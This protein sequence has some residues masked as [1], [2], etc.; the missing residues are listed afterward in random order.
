[1]ANPNSGALTYN[2]SLLN[3]EYVYPD[4]VRSS[5]VYA[6]FLMNHMKGVSKY[7]SKMQWFQ[8]AISQ[9]TVTIS[10][11]YTA[12]DATISVTAPSN[13]SPFDTEI[14]ANVS[15][16][17]TQ[18][19]SLRFNVT[20]VNGTFTVLTVSVA[21]GT[22][23]NL[24]AGTKLFISR[25]GDIGDDFGTQNDISTATT[26]YNFI[27]SFSHTL[28][29]A[30]PIADGSFENFGENELS[31]SRQLENLY[32]TVIRNMER[33]LLKDSRIEGANPKSGAGFTRTA[34]TGAQAG[35]LVSF[36]SSGGGYT[37][38]SGLAALTESTLITDMG[39]LRDRGAF[40]NPSAMERSY[41]GDT[42]D[43]Y[44]SP[45]TLGDIN[46][47]VRLERDDKALSA[48]ENG[49]FGTFVTQVIA[50][51]V[52]VS[53]YLSDGIADNEVIYIPKKEYIE[54]KVMRLAEEQPELPGGD[55]TKKMFATTFSLCV[56]APW[57][58]GHRTNLVRL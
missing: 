43:A 6:P 24:A 46:K 23:T 4:I 10:S 41:G 31:F 51:G 36:I 52:L 38:S 33:G 35:G 14:K 11:N 22:D 49:K 32:P 45:A 42:C 21:S 56:K 25:R 26:D 2:D 17:V 29:I 57:I 53:F 15:Q 44:I 16:L 9:G 12:S 37:I 3:K 55:N 7:N 58:L 20:A 50:D 39:N 5:R 47:L 28:K 19:G 54:A 8:Q 27:T 13:Y 30:N 48:Q 40:T 34:G 18:D 1:M